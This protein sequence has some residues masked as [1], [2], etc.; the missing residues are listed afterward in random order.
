[1]HPFRSTS[2]NHLAAFNDPYLELVMARR[3]EEARWGWIPFAAFVSFLFVYRIFGLFMPSNDADGS[4]PW[5]FVL[6]LAG[7][8]LLALIHMIVLPIWMLIASP[9]LLGGEPQEAGGDG[10]SVQCS[11]PCLH[12]SDAVLLVRV[13]LKRGLTVPLAAAGKGHSAA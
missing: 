12:G 3:K 2:A 8:G 1:M 9:P 4:E 10:A 11:C 7:W 13:R 5:L 6:A